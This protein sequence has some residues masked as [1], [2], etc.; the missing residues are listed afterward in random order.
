V[1]TQEIMDETTIM[2]NPGNALDN[3]NAHEMAT[4]LSDAQDGGYKFVVI[5]MNS[6]EFLSS[7]GVGSI[8]GLVEMSRENG[9]DIIL[10]NPSEKILHILD[11]LD[12]REY[13]TV[14]CENTKTVS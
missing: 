5:D 10:Q 7:A 12:L 4:A 14:Q 9:G 6:L 2:L 8:L 11:V 1:I 3:D 13:L